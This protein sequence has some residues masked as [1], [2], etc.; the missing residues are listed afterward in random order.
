M[1]FEE[2]KNL[3]D[4]LKGFDPKVT[5]GIIIMFCLGL[6]SLYS[7]LLAVFK[8]RAGDDVKVWVGTLIWECVTGLLVAL[9]NGY[10]LFMLISHVLERLIHE[11]VITWVWVFLFFYGFGS[12][13]HHFRNVS[14]IR[15]FYNLFG[16]P[17]VTMK[18]LAK[19]K[20]ENDAK[21]KAELDSVEAAEAV[22]AAML[23]A[24]RDDAN[25]LAQIAQFEHL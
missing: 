11:K 7:G 6:F 19:K 21:L 5:P 3:S 23:H 1:T 17:I 14:W 16:H 2:I 15:F 25:D 20:L 22:E 4:Y 9:W 12:A 8:R 10:N 24:Q 13:F 18:R